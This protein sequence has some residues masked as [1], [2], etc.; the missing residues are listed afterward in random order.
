MMRHFLLIA[1]LCF[2]ALPACAI[3]LNEELAYR[4]RFSRADDILLLLKK[5]ADVNAVNDVGLP[6]VSVA[7]SRTDDDAISVLRVLMQNGADLNRGG[8]NNQYPVVIAARENNTKMMEFLIKEAKVD[9]TVK[10]LNGMLPLEIAEYYGNKESAD[11]IRDLTQ[12]KLAQERER[13]SPARQAKL[14]KELAFAVCEEE[15][16]HYYYI[17]KQDKHSKEEIANQITKRRMNVKDAMNELYTIFGVP[18]EITYSMKKMME[19]EIVKQLDAMISNRQ[20]RA[21]G[22]GSLADL[23]MRCDPLRDKW[24]AD[25]ASREAAQKAEE[26]KRKENLRRTFAY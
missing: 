10:D 22:I 24:Y 3:T 5:G 14:T 7:T 16:M 9:Y 11:Y 13:R 17:S 26:A 25:Y 21:K 20:R 23:H 6:M 18:P 8:P 4:V 15:Y 19:P 1:L 12:E 2:T